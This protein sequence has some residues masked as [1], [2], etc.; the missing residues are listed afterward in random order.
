MIIIVIT[1]EHLLLQVFAYVFVFV[2]VVY[3]SNHKIIIVL[4]DGHQYT[5]PSIFNFSNYELQ[6]MKLL[7]NV[8]VVTDTP[9]DLKDAAE[10][11]VSFI[12]ILIIPASMHTV[13][14]SQHAI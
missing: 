6:L 12:I 1:L 4:L 9:Y 2:P 13:F 11:K 8:I 5:L 10:L 3:I 14:N 7:L